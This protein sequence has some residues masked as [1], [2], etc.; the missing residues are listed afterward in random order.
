MLLNPAVIIIYGK[1]A[2]PLTVDGYSEKV[3]KS[4]VIAVV[5]MMF[6]CLMLTIRIPTEITIL[7]RIWNGFARTVTTLNT[8][9]RD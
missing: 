5:L 1:V 9:P 2:K 8:T 3:I 6:G 4:D 7:L